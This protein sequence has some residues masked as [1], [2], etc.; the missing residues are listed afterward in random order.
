MSL[1]LACTLSAAMAVSLASSPAI[2]QSDRPAFTFDAPKGITAA[3][4]CALLAPGEDQH[5][6]TLVGLQKWPQR[7]DAYL[8]IV[9]L[10]PDKVQYDVDREYCRGFS[11][12]R[13]GY[14]GFNEA[15]NPRRVFLGVLEFRERLRL[16]ASSG[17]PL[18]VV[19]TW[20]QSNI[21]PNDDGVKEEGAYPGIYEGFDLAPYKVAKDQVA[22]GLRVG[23]QTMYSGGGG[24]F[25]ALM[26]FLV[27]G[28]RI[29][30]VLSEPI[31]ESGMAGGAAEAKREWQTKNVLR[32]LPHKHADHFDLQL[33]QRGGRWKQTF[34]WDAEAKRYLPQPR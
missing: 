31:E 5:L 32:I 23:W 20:E 2:S 16:V 33:K 22:I 30:N 11:C 24:M 19:T 9:C 7:E 4:V 6:A 10:A 14:G 18:K 29:V 17:G 27:D 28:D 3:D 12:C 21:D 8:G 25:E 26:L 34:Q 1:R 15:K 13:A